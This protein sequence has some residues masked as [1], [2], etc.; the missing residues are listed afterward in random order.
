M[1]NPYYEKLVHA[2]LRFVSF[3]PRSEKEFTDFLTKKLKNWKV[4]GSI[5]IAGVVERMREL[6]YVDDKKFASWWVEQ[7]SLYRPKGKRA[8]FFE[9]KKKGVEEEIQ[10][11]EFEIA[12]KA[13]SK[14]IDIWA[15]LA[16]F[17]QKKKVYTFLAQRG[18]SSDTI[19]R[20]IDG[21]NQKD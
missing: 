15:K 4:S 2:A 7:R 10:F 18:F 17:E 9:L 12:R 8:I 21:L 16:G 13:I 14:K 5:L 1:N 19:E 3:R 11:D 20:I 6:G